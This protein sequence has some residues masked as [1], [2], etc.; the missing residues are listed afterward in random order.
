MVIRKTFLP[1]R[2][3]QPWVN[4][5]EKQEVFILGGFLGLAWQSHSKHDLVLGLS[6]SK[7]SFGLDTSIGLCH[8][9]CSTLILGPG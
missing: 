2:M 9:C 8:Q 5:W 4:P 3:V 6:C 1:R 7:W